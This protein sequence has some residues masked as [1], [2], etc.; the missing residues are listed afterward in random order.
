MS[1]EEPRRLVDIL[2]QPTLL[3]QMV[4]DYLGLGRR[5]RQGPI[6]DAAALR[7]F[8]QT[9]ASFV[10][11]TSL[12]GY[13]RTRTGMPMKSTPPFLAASRGSLHGERTLMS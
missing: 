5:R 9:R 11:Q 2:S 7:E 12:Y 1:I 4:L 6:E 3:W 8:L 10:A 13:L